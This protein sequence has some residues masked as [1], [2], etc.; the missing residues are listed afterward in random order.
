MTGTGTAIGTGAAVDIETLMPTLEAVRANCHISDARFATQYTLCVYLLKMREFFR[1]E[2]G[3]PFG[4][5]LPHDELTGWLTEREEHWEELE[6]AEFRAVPVGDRHFDPF[7]SAAINAALNPL[8]YI[9]SSGYG[10]SMKPVF[11]LG[12]LEQRRSHADFTLLVSGRELARDLAAPPAMSLADTI[13]IRRE[14]LRRMLWERIEEWRWNQPDNAM[15][16]ALGCY[17][18]DRDP[19]AA[20]EAM[21]DNELHTVLL[22]EI[23]ELRAGMLLGPEWEALL[24]GLGHSKAEIMLRAV[25][26]HLADALSTLPGLLADPSPAVLHGY[27]AGL[28]NMRRLLFPQLAQAY[29]AWRETG[30]TGPLARLVEPAVEH[31]SSVTRQILDLFSLRPADPGPAIIALIESRP[32]ELDPT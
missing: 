30:H 5:P 19:A 4:A 16:H 27:F 24:A 11:F 26:D 12:A 21:T 25:R 17:D 20:L 7:D 18:F 2:R 29:E 3:L 8:G 31:W 28:S 23:G 6:D 15:K 1:W 14:S 9:Y 22:H 32:L 10:A 13:F